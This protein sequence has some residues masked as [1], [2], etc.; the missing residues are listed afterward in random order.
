MKFGELV[1]ALYLHDFTFAAKK[2]TE[3]GY[4]GFD[5]RGYCVLFLTGHGKLKDCEVG[6]IRV[7]VNSLSIDLIGPEQAQ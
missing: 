6:E 3:N 2:K 5:D 1:D 4:E 7:G